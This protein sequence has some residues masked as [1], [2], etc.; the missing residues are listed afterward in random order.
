MSAIQT[1]YPAERTLYHVAYQATGHEALDE[2]VNHV[3][4]N[5]PA[6]FNLFELKPVVINNNGGRVMWGMRPNKESKLATVMDITVFENGKI[7]SLDVF[8][9]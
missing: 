3:L 6:A 1:I 9:N 7:K 2:S 8:F 4:T 5:M